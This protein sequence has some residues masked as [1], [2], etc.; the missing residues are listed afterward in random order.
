MMGDHYHHLIINIQTNTSLLTLIY[1]SVWYQHPIWCRYADM[2]RCRYADMHQFP[3]IK[4][5]TH[6]TL[7]QPRKDLKEIKH[8]KNIKNTKEHKN[9]N[10]VGCP[11][12]LSFL[13]NVASNFISPC[14]PHFFP[15][16][17]AF[18]SD[19]QSTKDA[20]P[21]RP[22]VSS[23]LSSQT[24]AVGSTRAQSSSSTQQPGDRRT[25]LLS[26]TVGLLLS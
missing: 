5:D 3:R 18:P 22:Q 19:L 10:R 2:Q 12:K 9:S 26:P 7:T 25:A 24:A 11:N 16:S 4:S 8:K 20:F 21:F 17:N 15:F 13:S 6:K 14:F 23:Q 1:W